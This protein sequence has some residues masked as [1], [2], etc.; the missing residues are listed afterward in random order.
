MRSVSD[1]VSAVLAAARPMPPLDVVLADADGCVLAED[2]TAPED[3]PLRPVADRDGYAVRSADVHPWT[4]VRLPVVD[5]A[6]PT[7]RV[8]HLV[9]G[10]AVLVASGA[11]LP[12]GADAVVALEDTDRGRAH[13]TVRGVVRAGDG[14]RPAGRDA[15]AGVPVLR[16][17][18]RLGARHLA[19]AAAMGRSRLWVRPAP[20][21]V[22]VTVGDELVDAGRPVREGRVHDADGHALVAA[23]REAGASAVR[24]GPVG[25]DRG[26]LREV[27]SDQM[28]RADLLVLTGGLSA[29]PWDTVVDVLAPLGEFRLDSVA[30]RPGGR[31]GFGLLGTAEDGAMVAALPG[32]PVAALLSFEMFIRPAVRTMAGYAELF[33]PSV[34]ATA[35]LPWGSPAGVT[36]LVPGSVVGTSGEGYVMT[37]LGDPDQ[38][39]LAALAGANVLAVVPE[40]TTAVL[41]GD[42]VAC[43]VLEG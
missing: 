26:V 17:G 3:V 28:V 19:L 29:G 7:S 16:S 1:H 43:L 38:V 22:V 8:V 6:R 39:S 41:A 13:V 20:R 40:G 18:V 34:R 11:P 4:E 37:P 27:L 24:V 21:I 10:S 35:A 5:D 14:V 2:L 42:E 31:Q 33:R 12:H 36:Q 9:P 15:A 23:A 25:D 32:H 30:M